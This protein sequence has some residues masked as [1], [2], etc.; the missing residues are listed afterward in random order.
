MKKTKIPMLLAGLVLISNVM[1]TGL[2][3]SPVSLTTP[4]SKSSSII[5]VSNASDKPLQAQIRV[6][7]WRQEDNKDVLEETSQ[8]IASPPFVTLGPGTKQ[9]VRLVRTS[10][11][12]QVDEANYRLIVDELPIPD[13]L[14]KGINLNLR[15]S[16]PL[17]ISGKEVTKVKPVVDVN[18]KIDGGLLTVSIKNDSEV[19]AQIGTIKLSTNLNTANLSTGLVG[20][21]LPKSAME[22]KFSVKE[23]DVDAKSLTI[24]VDGEPVLFEK[25]I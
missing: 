10:P 4:P 20:Y 2:Q 24:N 6:F 18:W 7:A 11:S 13:Q 16:I 1:A 23:I 14:Q 25:K 12:A 17:R 9:L 19:R 21:V 15:Y 8:I 22:W 5:H 3:V